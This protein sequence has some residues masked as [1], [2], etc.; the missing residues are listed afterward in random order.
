[1]DE[2]CWTYKLLI[3]HRL[4][5]HRLGS[6][7]VHHAFTPYFY[8]IYTNC[9]VFLIP[10]SKSSCSERGVA[11]LAYYVL[12]CVNSAYLIREGT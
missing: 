9:D 1:M 8:C 4:S 6:V 5:A 10:I 2:S 11:L 7:L 3:L 12:M